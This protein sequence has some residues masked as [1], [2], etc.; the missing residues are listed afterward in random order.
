MRGTMIANKNIIIAVL[1]I[2]CS[3]GYG[4]AMQEKDQG[5]FSWFSKYYWWGK[6]PAKKPNPISTSQ[7]DG[8]TLNSISLQN[9]NS[10]SDVSQQD[11]DG[12]TLLHLAIIN[13]QPNEALEIIRKLAQNESNK[14]KEILSLKNK[15]LKT[16][17]YLAT[18][19]G[20][21]TE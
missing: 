5:W 10:E 2:G 11:T 19:N 4:T 15:T 18:L 16:P 3:M 17:L 20:F 8:L 1:L 6:E 14:L 12:N 9:A 21:L 13:N 7:S